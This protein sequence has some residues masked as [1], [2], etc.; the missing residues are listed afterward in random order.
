[1]ERKFSEFKVP[2]LKA[3][4]KREGHKGYSKLR[5]AEL[6]A[7]LTATCTRPPK[8]ARPPPPPPT[9]SPPTPKPDRLLDKERQPTARQIKR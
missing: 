9:L 6:I 5:K 7:L 1:M 3:I 8:P 4:T 2:Q